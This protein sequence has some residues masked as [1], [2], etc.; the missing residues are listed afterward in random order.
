[1]GNRK[2]EAFY[3]HSMKPFEI[4]EPG[5]NSRS[6]LPANAG[7]QNLLKILDSDFHRN[8][9][10]S[11]FRTFFEAF[12]GG[13]LKIHLRLLILGIV[14]CLALP[15]AAAAWAADAPLRIGVLAIRGTDQCLDAW[16]PTADYLNR[17]VAG[18]RFRIVPLTHEQIHPYVREGKVDFIL[19]NS[20][21][22]VELE[23]H[24]RVSR[25]AT[26]KERHPGGVS[27]QYGGVVFCRSD[28]T[29]I[30]TFS[31]LTGKSFMAVSE[32][33]LGGW[34]MA[35][36]EF[37][38]SGIDPYTDFKSLSFGETHDQVVYAVRDR[39][40]DAGTVRTG[41]LEALSAE[42]NID[43]S[44]FYV[45]PMRHE[46]DEVLPY[47]CTTRQYP[48]WPMARV[49]HTPD[50][51]AEK[52]SVALLKMPPDAIAAQVSGYAG[53]TI[54]SDY[55][56]VHECMKFLKI[57]PYE[58]LGRITFSDI[59]HTYGH[60]IIL[61][62]ALFCIMG[63]FAM[64]AMNLNKRMKAANIRL[65]G[66]MELR[67]EKERELHLAKE[68]A[69][70]ATRAKSEFLANMS[71]EIRTPMNGVIAAADLALGEPV[72]PKIEHYLKI[73]HGSAY[74]LLGIINDIL[75]FSKIEA[76]KFE[77]KERVF[78]LGQ[79]IDQ[80]MELFVNK[81]AE[82]GIELLVDMEVNAPKLLQGDPLRL[83]QILT[84]L[85]SN[86][87]KF[88]D[89]GGVIR[90]DVMELPETQEAAAGDEIVLDFSVTDT[91]TGIAP[92][93]IGQLFEPFSQADTSSTRKYEGTGLGL[94]ICKQLVTMMGGEIGVQSEL[95]KG[96]KFYFTVR[97]RRPADE[98][99]PRLVVPQDIR[100]L[101]VLV[102]DDLA[103]S[104][105]IMRKMLTSLGFKV[106]T[107]PS[108]VDAMRRLQPDKMRDDPVELIMMDW[109]MPEMDGIETSR[110]IREE[111]GL[112]LPIIMMTAFGKEEQRIRAQ[113]AGINGYLTKPIYPSTL[114][115]AIMDG[116]GKE[117]FKAPG[118]EKEFTTK[119]SIYRKPLR[120]AR[121][122]VAEDNPTNQQVALAILEGAGMAVTI[123]NNGEE[124]V[125]AVQAGP[126]DAVL[127]DI[128]M[129]RMNGY[130]ATRTIR[131]IPELAHLPIVA[132]TAHA[133]KGDEEKCLEAGM[134]GYIS[135]PVNQDRLFHT[136]WRVIRA[137]GGDLK[138]IASA[139]TDI[140]AGVGGDRDGVKPDRELSEPE[141]PTEQ[142]FMLPAA[143][144]G[145]DIGRTLKAL[146]IDGPTFMR[147]LK[148]FEAH[149]R[150]M[151]EKLREAFAA[152]DVEQI[153]QVAHALKGS[154]ANIGAAALSA[155]AASLEEASSGESPA[156]QHLGKL[157]DAVVAALDQVLTSIQTLESAKPAP[158]AVSA[159]PE[160]CLSLEE[161]LQE[162]AGAVDRADP[163]HIMKL[164]PAI[165]QQAGSCQQM[166]RC[167]LKTLETQ[168]ARYDYD[169]A[170]ETI[171]KLSKK[172]QKVP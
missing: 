143:L 47:L 171:R 161:L 166:D 146:E 16:T 147:I 139:A 121:I 72:P 20:A 76:G 36:R 5:K 88:T 13:H 82:K 77:L 113:A 10:K 79:V 83:Q 71:H 35:W 140:E 8:D 87:I 51:L 58:D 128:Q 17:Q 145:I 109:K 60:W 32:V 81:A 39:R 65:H 30:R 131:Q 168:L 167:S 144:P 149:H 119:A 80:V 94:S 11:E 37:K 43:L 151:G 136:L 93:Y 105:T 127:M 148:G 25:I 56:P 137:H 19:T 68:M 142:P 96:S 53:W 99:L 165:E 59:L 141:V 103:D 66:E 110:R 172:G 157:I 23:Y 100:G 52:V 14:L 3:G 40:V 169:E 45:F 162:L 90:M 97:M 84:N 27:T 150:P 130:E 152:S 122:L 106:E 26:L 73:I 98:S 38:E 9:G 111:L 61:A 112:T 69:E 74:S 120:G 64:A 156:P 129:P 2:E 101:K 92:E 125:Q 28:R 1:M 118:R 126:F 138:S 34:I 24:Y 63:G 15:A 163:E 70:S 91:G 42:G 44:D 102:V 55:Q 134:D 132:M 49:K 159:S 170:L 158:E 18:R 62:T 48:G 114:F 7:I 117:G 154:G 54:P 4:D 6:V 135:K 50:S 21:S 108:G 153:R 107:L 116:F 22:Y 123:V 46:T 115:D 57:G 164:M 124:A 33:S 31:E 86:A 133:M 67:R 78:R 85:V 41:T 75:D 12:K 155:A 160:A 95:G 29:D 89:T 104:R